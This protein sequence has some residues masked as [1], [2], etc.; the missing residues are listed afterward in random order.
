[1]ALAVWATLSV[2]E[3]ADWLT[4][5]DVDGAYDVAMVLEIER[6]CGVI[7]TA[8]DPASDVEN[9]ACEVSTGAVIGMLAS[10]E[11]SVA[12]PVEKL[13]E[14]EGMCVVVKVRGSSNVE[15]MADTL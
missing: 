11:V 14:V 10:N 6:L 9:D 12:A 15:Y 3:F 4:E 2:F 5:R 8:A 7:V 13:R 1:V